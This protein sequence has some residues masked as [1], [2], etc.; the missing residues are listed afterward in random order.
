[1][2]VKNGDS[3]HLIAFESK[4]EKDQWITAMNQVGGRGWL[5]LMKLV[6]ELVQ[7]DFFE[8][9][10]VWHFLCKVD[11]IGRFYII[12][13]LFCLFVKVCLVK[14]QQSQ[15]L[16]LFPCVCEDLLPGS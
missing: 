4:E 12:L 8:G 9:Y 3:E 10:K 11:L 16:G 1:V 14:W 2:V 7:G 5:L 13:L 15:V 6:Q